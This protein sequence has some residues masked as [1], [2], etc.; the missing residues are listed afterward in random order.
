MGGLTTAKS[1]LMLPIKLETTKDA[2]TRAALATKLGVMVPYVKVG[3]IEVEVDWTVTNLDSDAAQ[4]VIDFNAGNEFWYYDPTLINLAAPGD[5][6]APPTPQLQGNIPT[7]IGPNAV[8]TGTFRE[9]QTLEASVD[10]DEITRGN[11]TPFYATNVVDKNDPSFQ[12]MSAPM[13]DN[14]DYVPSPVGPV[15][16][17]AAFAEIIRYDFTFKPDHH[18]TMTYEV[19]IRDIRGIVDPKGLDAPASELTMFAPMPYTVG[20]PATGT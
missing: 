8:L 1:S 2:A 7:D 20:P 10:L 3:D 6:E 19:R 14:V 11:I 12:P 13:P 15:I 9:D 4:F 5:D 18:M 16:P 17:R